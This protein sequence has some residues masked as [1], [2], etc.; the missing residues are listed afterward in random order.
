MQN[1]KQTNEVSDVD[2]DFIIEETSGA[3]E[4]ENHSSCDE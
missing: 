3:D 4:L 1:E 2:F